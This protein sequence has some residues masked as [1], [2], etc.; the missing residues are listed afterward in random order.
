MG[1]NKQFVIFY[2]REMVPKQNE[3]GW[4]AQS[5]RRAC[6]GQARPSRTQ[7]LRPSPQIKKCC[8]AG[9][10]GHRP[11]S[12]RITGSCTGRILKVK[13]D[14]QLACTRKK[15]KMARWFGRL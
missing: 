3:L 11:V 7:E 9:F 12:D 14:N 10:S 1:D 8:A 15:A 2:G 4:H 6:W 13:T 5:P